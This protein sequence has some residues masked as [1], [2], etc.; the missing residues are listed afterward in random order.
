MKEIPWSCCLMLISLLC[1]QPWGGRWHCGLSPYRHASWYACPAL[2]CLTIALQ[3]LA[4]RD[5]GKTLDS[6]VCMPTNT[7]SFSCRSS[8][9]GYSLLPLLSQIFCTQA[10]KSMSLWKGCIQNQAVCSRW[11]DSHTGFKGSLYNYMSLVFTLAARPAS[12][13]SAQIKRSLIS[14]KVDC[15]LWF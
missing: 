4:N 10:P 7:R 8:D 3:R 14:D 5:L 2:S 12:T 9:T 6:S 15:L 1:F 13:M 11:T